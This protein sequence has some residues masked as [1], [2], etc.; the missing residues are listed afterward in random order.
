MI[1]VSSRRKSGWSGDSMDDDPVKKYFEERAAEFDSFYEGPRNFVD[2]LVDKVFR[3]GMRE[4]VTI[5]LEEAGD[6][7]RGTKVLDVGCGAGRVSIPLAAR[8]AE[9]TGIDLARSMIE[10]GEKHLRTYERGIGTRLRVQFIHA[11]IMAFATGEVFEV[12]LALGLF[13]YVKD[14]S[15]LLRRMKELTRGKIIASFPARYTFQAPIRKVWLRTRDCVV[16]FYT[17][18]KLRKIY[19]A[20][21]L[22]V[23]R[24][25]DVRAGYMVIANTQNAPDG[26]RA[27]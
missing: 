14:P 22:P 20:V 21:G 10:L 7:L 2:A 1:S 11:D 24:I 5:T 23:R 16:Y 6:D 4:R 26:T 17:K 25:V 3:R 19:D 8:G 27:V 12:T 13:D 18:G 15:P 9:V